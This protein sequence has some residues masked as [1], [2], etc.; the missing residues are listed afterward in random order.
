MNKLIIASSSDL[1]KIIV[2]DNYEKLVD[3]RNYCSHL[4]FKIARYIE[5]NG[6][7]AA[8]EDAHYV[9]KGVADRLN[10]AQSSLP[11]GFKLM[12][13][14]AYRSPKMQQKSYDA[15]YKKLQK[16]HPSWVEKQLEIEMEKRVSPV[17][18]AP[19]CTGGTIDLTIVNTDNQQLDM[20]TS[21]DE[22][23]EK[24]YTNSQSISNNA[25]KNRSLLIKV[26]TSAGFVNFPAEWW[27][28]SYGDREWAN[29]QKN[30]TAI[31]DLIE[32]K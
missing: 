17:D 5:K 16:E 12:I 20:G 6:G 8:V 11:K 7:S 13:E 25:I 23:S 19:H 18:I 21:L 31:Y 3:L 15:V 10:I 14:C 28:W 32:K 22:F 9:R 30:K 2:K 4:V 29:L 26:M 1:R 24:T 27:H